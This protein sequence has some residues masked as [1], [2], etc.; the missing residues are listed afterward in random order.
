MSLDYSYYNYA[1]RFVEEPF[2]QLGKD[3]A[4]LIKSEYR[5]PV[6]PGN[7]GFDLRYVG[8][9]VVIQPNQTVKIHT[10]I[11]IHLKNP[12]TVGI[13]TPRSGLGS[14]GLILGNSVGVI[15]SNYQGEISAVV[16]NRTD[17]PITLVTGER[18]CQLLIM[19]CLPHQQQ[20]TT[21]FDTTT[22]RGTDGFG[23]T[24]RV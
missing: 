13:I 7:A 9:D 11:A 22:E 12:A 2:E 1:I 6:D 20:W 24:G 21:A 4:Q 23:S 19:P 10:G 5:K 8:E 17:E 16:W 14:K 15:D 18:F 3:A